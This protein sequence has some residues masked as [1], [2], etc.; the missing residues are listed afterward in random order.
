MATAPTGSKPTPQITNDTGASNLASLAASCGW[1]PIDR[2]PFF[3]CFH[4]LRTSKNRNSGNNWPAIGF[5]VFRF[6]FLGKNKGE[7]I[8]MRWRHSMIL[9]EFRALFDKIKENARKMGSNHTLSIQPRRIANNWKYHMALS[10]LSRQTAV[11]LGIRRHCVIQYF[12]KKR[13]AIQW[14]S[15]WYMRTITSRI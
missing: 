1:P 13:R 8:E 5:W 15:K 2:E 9:P 7:N 11:Y 14:N 12:R 6:D 10:G 4:A 3:R